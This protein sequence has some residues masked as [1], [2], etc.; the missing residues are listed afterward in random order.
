M[1]ERRKTSR[2][3]DADDWYPSWSPFGD[4]IAFGSDRSGNHDVYVMAID[5]RN[6]T[7]LTHNAETDDDPNWS[8]AVLSI[9]P[10]GRQFV[11]MG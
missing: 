9:S 1:V 5:D 7:K 3:H 4:R 10:A 11:I 6:L 8:R 2:R